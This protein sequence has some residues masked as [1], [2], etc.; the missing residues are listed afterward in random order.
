MKKRL[1]ITALIFYYRYYFSKYSFIQYLKCIPYIKNKINKTEKELEAS[2][3]TSYSN[4]TAIPIKPVQEA[5]ILSWFDSHEKTQSQNISGIIYYNNQNHFDLLFKVF[6]KYAFTNPLHP[7]VFPTIR[8]MEI[9]IINMM[10]KQFWGDEETCGNVTSGGTESILL[11]CYTYR[12]WGRKEYGIT[13]PNIVAFHSVHP[14]FDKACHYFGIK[15]TKVSSVYW[16]K[17]RTNH[18]T[19]CVVGS[20]PTYA[21]GIMDP[22]S[23]I[24]HYCAF[25][26]IPFHVDCCMG[27]FLVPFLDQNAVQFLNPGITSISA[28]SHK[29][30][31]TFKGSSILLFR[32]YSFK[33]HQHFV[34]TDWEGGIY[35]TPT[36]LGSKSGALIATTWAS[37]L[38]IG[39]EKYR[40]IAMDI[41]SKLERIKKQFKN[42]P[43]IE[44]IGNPTINIIAFKSSK[45]DIY[46]VV[47]KMDGWNLSILTNP[48]AFHFCITSLHTYS[49]I[50]TFID[51]LQKAVNEVKKNP[52][53]E[54]SGTLAVYGSATKIENSMF[55][56]DV[57]NQYAALLSSKKCL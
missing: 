23:E 8:E 51:H 22:I 55:T 44:I 18:N 40:K 20:A 16:M 17:K 11:A 24:S 54:L 36:L 30:G 19:I 12:E 56:Y 3:E 37:M 2:L 47:S 29:Y 21:Y 49:I 45:I 53:N 5:T 57:V 50:D 10:V 25:W 27:G 6:K 33:K 14:A 43:D 9:D 31:N 39:A 48:P 15:L 35:A 1:L 4:I 38:A 32:N 42:N 28:D 34:K 46:K 26:K 7:D 13:N 52:D 41:K